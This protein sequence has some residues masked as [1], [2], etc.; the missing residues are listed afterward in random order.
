MAK[1]RKKF[2][3]Q[4]RNNQYL[5]GSFYSFDVV[6]PLGNYPEITN[7]NYGHE[8]SM[9]AIIL[10]RNLRSLH[11]ITTYRKLKWMVT[12]TVEFCHN[13]K[14]Y[15]R[16][17]QIGIHGILKDAEGHYQDLIEGIFDQ[18]NMDHY[19]CCHVKAKIIGTDV[20]KDNDFD[21]AA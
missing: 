1:K 21:I 12:V 18:S 14:P 15:F 20:I 6:D 10:K 16:E 9:K 4:K 17:A 5:I 8:N 19:V 11:E 3:R 2:S 7:T 13:G